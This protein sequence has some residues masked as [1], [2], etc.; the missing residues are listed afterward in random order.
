[1]LKHDIIVVGASAGGV[2]ALSTLARGLPPDLAAAVFVVLHVPPTATSTL[3]RILARAGTLPAA[4]AVDG[5]AIRPGRIFVAPPGCHLLIDEEQVHLVRGP[6][7]NGHRPAADPLFRSAA[8]AYGAR[9]VGV[10]LS[11]TLDDGTA[12]LRAVKQ[13]GGI[14]IV[15]DPD[16][17]LFSGMPCSALEHVAVDHRVPAAQIGPLLATL[18]RAPAEE[19]APAMSQ[20][21]ALRSKID[22]QELRLRT[23]G[24]VPGEASGFTC[25][26]CHGALWELGDGDPSRFECRIGHRYSTEALLAGETEALEAALWT[27]LRALKEKAALERRIALQSRLRGR[28]LMAERFEEQADDAERRAGLI[29]QALTSAL[30][31]TAETTSDRRGTDSRWGQTEG[32]S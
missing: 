23:S 21:K 24:K 2:E 19:G 1:M 7:E 28:R 11:G 4:H 26:E 10:V 29:E 31:A 27:A 9:V 25:P 12:G 32:G 17:A 3:P 6:K 30:P 22:E 14:A 5:E 16:D 13:R 18:A 20:D 8:A 15:Q